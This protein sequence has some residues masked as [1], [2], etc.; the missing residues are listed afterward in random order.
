MGSDDDYFCAGIVVVDRKGWIENKI[1][2]RALD[3]ARREPQKCRNY[4]Q[5]IL[6]YLL[7]GRVNV[8][9]PTWW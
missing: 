4:D 9:D 7:H 2:A 3:I 5:T 8:V 1:P 6:N